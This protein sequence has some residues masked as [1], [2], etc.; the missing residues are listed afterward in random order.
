[1]VGFNGLIYVCMYVCLG[2]CFDVKQ[3]KIVARL[4]HVAVDSVSSIFGE[5]L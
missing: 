5:V 3:E 2:N 4:F 1:M